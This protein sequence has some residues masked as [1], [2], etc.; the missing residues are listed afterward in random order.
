MPFIMADD[1]EIYFT[2]QGQGTPILFIHPPLL[3]H[4]NFENQMKELS[5]DFQVITFDIRGHGRSSFSKQHLTYP[6]IAED[7]KHLLDHLKIQKAFICGYST[8]GTIALEFLLS[9]PDRASGG[10][11]IS[12]M[13]EVSDWVL[14][15]KIRV[16]ITLT[17]LK[18]LSALA[19]FIAWTNSTKSSFWKMVKE[20]QKGNAQNIEEY[21]QYSLSYNCTNKLKNIN[22]PILL[23]YG[24]KDQGFHRYAKLLHEKLPQ[25]ELIWIQD[26]KHQLPTKAAFLLNSQIKQFIYTYK[27]P[28]VK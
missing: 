3:T 20:E 22:K 4:F 25:N 9:N 1:C 23:I 27:E 14:R 21:Y 24:Q 19:L 6:L 10:I 28:D 8:G 17:K 12:G 2:V 26:V 5:R 15:N 18:G 11:L 13:S 16:A 7:M